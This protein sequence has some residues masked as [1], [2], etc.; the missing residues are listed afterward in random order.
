MMGKARKRFSQKV[1]Q[2]Q[3]GGKGRKRKEGSRQ[4]MQNKKSQHRIACEEK[5]RV[6][7]RNI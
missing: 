7:N 3:A 6:S 2:I 4:S 1:D 5:N